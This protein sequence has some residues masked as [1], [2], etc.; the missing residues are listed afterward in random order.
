MVTPFWIS[1]CRRQRCVPTKADVEISN[2]GNELSQAIVE[3]FV[4]HQKPPLPRKMMPRSLA[5]ATLRL[6]SILPSIFTSNL[7]RIFSNVSHDTF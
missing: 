5:Q 7:S 1:S 2:L 3:A 4:G 6:R